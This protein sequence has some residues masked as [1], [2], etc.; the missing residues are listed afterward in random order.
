MAPKSWATDEQLAWLRDGFVA[1]Y[2]H[3]QAEKKL[4][5]FWG[6]L[7]HQ[8]FRDFPEHVALG[9]PLPGDENGRKLTDEETVILGAAILSRKKASHAQRLQLPPIAQILTVAARNLK[10][11][12]GTKAKRSETPVQR[13]Q[14]S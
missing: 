1:D 9:L 3:R 13:I 6:A 5:L 12:F 10:T 8:W 2:P 14:R 11:G 7:H 4:H